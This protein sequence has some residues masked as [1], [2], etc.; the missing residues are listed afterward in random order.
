MNHKRRLVA[1]NRQLHLLLREVPLSYEEKAAIYNSI[2]EPI[3]KLQESLDQLRAE[4]LAAVKKLE[5]MVLLNR[6]KDGRYTKQVETYRS[7][8][9][10]FHQAVRD[11]QVKREEAANAIYEVMNS[12]E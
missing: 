4:Y 11:L 5:E 12:L 7:L 8:R 1:N 6:N 3:V 9:T 2:R 10:R